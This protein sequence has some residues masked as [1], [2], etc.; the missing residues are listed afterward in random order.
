MNAADID[1]EMVE[2]GLQNNPAFRAVHILIQP[3]PRLD[4]CPLGLYVAERATIILP[5]DFTEA[6]FLHELGHRHGHYYYSNLSE[7]YAE[8]FRS[9]YQRGTT[10]LYAGA[11]FSRLASFGKLYREGEKGVILFGL[12]R[13]PDAY[14]LQT[15]KEQLYG[16]GEMPPKITLGNSPSPY[17]R[18]EFTKGVDWLV[19]IGASLVGVVAVTIGAIAYAVYKV[20]HDMPWIV[21]LTILGTASFLLLRVATRKPVAKRLIEAKIGER[22]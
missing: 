5:P 19:I 9:R 16:Y 11:D 21:P 4:G 12:E 14:E 13:L 20:S 18:L 15:I 8:N 10:L 6:A 2:K 7:R 1:R 3:I 17:M 22:R